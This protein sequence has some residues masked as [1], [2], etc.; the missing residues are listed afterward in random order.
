MLL[1]K[2]Q[3][4]TTTNSKKE[5]LGRELTTVKQQLQVKDGVISSLKFELSCAAQSSRADLELEQDRNR[6]LT[7]RILYL[8]CDIKENDY[9]FREDSFRG[10][11]GQR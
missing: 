7:E 3:A 10:N 11:T 6:A 9:A 1:E 5:S 8:V 4:M 2:L